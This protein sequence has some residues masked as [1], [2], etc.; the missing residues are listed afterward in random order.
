MKNKIWKNRKEF[1]KEKIRYEDNNQIFE[2][3]IEELIQKYD[4]GKTSEIIATNYKYNIKVQEILTHFIFFVYK[5][6]R[7]S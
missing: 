1:L 6:N 2:F 5:F 3:T 7:K 4:I